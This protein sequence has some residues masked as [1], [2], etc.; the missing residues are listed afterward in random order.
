[1]RVTRQQR[2]F[3]I[4]S[5]R[6]GATNPIAPLDTN[7]ALIAARNGLAECDAQLLD[8]PYYTPFIPIRRS[9]SF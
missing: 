7:R 5:A 1:M 6:L 4:A 2:A 3:D 9:A 8:R